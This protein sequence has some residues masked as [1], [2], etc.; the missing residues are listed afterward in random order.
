[1][2]ATAQNGQ[3]EAAL[4]MLQH[5]VYLRNSERVKV[6]LAK[7]YVQLSEKRKQEA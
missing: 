6:L 4:D 7:L 2:L 5:G 3:K 1:V